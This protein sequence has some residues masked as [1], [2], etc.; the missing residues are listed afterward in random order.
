MT[1]SF[2]VDQTVTEGREIHKNSFWNLRTL[3]LFAGLKSEKNVS[4]MHIRFHDL[5]GETQVA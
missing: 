1:A 5:L 3:G 2:E 4:H